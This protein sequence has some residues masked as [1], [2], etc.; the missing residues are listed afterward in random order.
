[1]EEIKTWV[2]QKLL[3]EREF[4]CREIDFRCTE[5]IQNYCR[6]K[7][8]SRMN[9]NNWLKDM[10]AAEN[11]GPSADWLYVLRKEMEKMREEWLVE[12][13]L[14][15]TQENKQWRKEEENRKEDER[16]RLDEQM[17]LVARLKEMEKRVC[18]IE[19]STESLVE[20][21]EMEKAR[22]EWL[23]ED[24]LRSTLESKRWIKKEEN[25]KEDERRRLDEQWDLVERLKE[26]ENRICN[27]EKWTERL[28][29][30][31]AKE[32]EEMKEFKKMIQTDMEKER[33]N[34]RQ[35]KE[36]IKRVREKEKEDMKEFETVIQRERKEM[37]EHIEKLKETQRALEKERALIEEE[38][39]K[40][41]EER[42]KEKKWMAQRIEEEEAEKLEMKREM[43]WMRTE[44]NQE[45]QQLKVYQQRDGLRMKEM[46]QLKIELNENLGAHKEKLE[47]QLR[48]R[49]LRMEKWEKQK[50]SDQELGLMA[51]S[52]KLQEERRIRKEAERKSKKLER[53]MSLQYL[54]LEGKI[55]TIVKDFAEAMEDMEGCS[56][57]RFKDVEYRVKQ[58]LKM[59]KQDSGVTVNNMLDESTSEKRKEK[60]KKWGFIKRCFKKSHTFL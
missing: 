51:A 56:S 20:R 29:K 50:S 35:Y 32:R 47:N 14:R 52:L 23:I 55:L 13:R 5:H 58:M 53:N 38:R 43:W 44:R 11:L 36:M 18:N 57:K 31:S 48:E 3:K 41:E 8:K 49:E 24:N 60:W 7:E 9:K 17:D 22:E 46:E 27:M 25:R 10:M 42:I 19:K 33:E 34:M 6:K 16:R 26:M 21:K 15:S 39:K 37:K 59:L 4:T 2:L 12:D 54:E 28:E 1:M 30:E 40:M 45:K